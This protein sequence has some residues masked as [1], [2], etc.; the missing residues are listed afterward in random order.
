MTSVC[1]SKTI[2]F[3]KILLYSFQNKRAETAI[4]IATMLAGIL[5]SVVNSAAMPCD[6][7]SSVHVVIV[8]VF[9]SAL[10]LHEM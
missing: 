8:T 3:N 2:G 9:C 1:A 10:F 5:T 4:M 6:K 7:N